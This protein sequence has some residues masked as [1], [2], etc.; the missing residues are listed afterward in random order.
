[1]HGLSDNLNFFLSTKAGY[2]VFAVICFVPEFYGITL[3]FDWL[4][5][6]RIEAMGIQATIVSE[7]TN[8]KVGAGFAIFL[9]LSIYFLALNNHTQMARWV[10]ICAVSIAGISYANMLIIFWGQLIF[11][12]ALVGVIIISLLPAMLLDFTMEK[13]AAHMSETK[14]LWSQAIEMKDKALAMKRYA[15]F[16]S[17]Y[18]E[19][20]EELGAEYG[21]QVA[22]KI[23]NLIRKEYENA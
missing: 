8:L 23:E 11:W 14:Q 7:D 6:A 21:E 5:T 13:M 18:E 2:T 15:K 17:Q 3:F 20:R 12:P 22:T 4:L 19:V 1:M 9:F 16:A 10:T